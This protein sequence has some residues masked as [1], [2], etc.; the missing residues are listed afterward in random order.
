MSVNK[1]RNISKLQTSY[2]IQHEESQLNKARRKK[3]LIRRL[4]A[5]FILAAA[6]SYL[7]I[8]TLVSQNSV[9]ADKTEEKQQL[10]KD[11]SALKKEEILLKEEVVKLNDDE[12][13]AK[14]ARKEYF[15]SEENEIIFTLPQEKKKQGEEKATN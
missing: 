10:E 14:L 3:G 7:M 9:L 2:S 4:T 13:I 15:L 6:I 11:L 8:S 12:Y 5:F 1:T